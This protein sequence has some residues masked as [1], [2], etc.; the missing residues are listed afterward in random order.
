M[1][2]RIVERPA[3]LRQEA[4][5]GGVG[6]V[7]DRGVILPLRLDVAAEAA[8]QVGPHGVEEVVVIEVEL[9]YRGERLIW[10]VHLGYGYGAIERRYRARC[11]C[12]ELIIQL[13]DLPP[14]GL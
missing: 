2:R 7:R 5:F 8:Q 13:E 3:P 4:L 1:S 6:A 14:V 11:E 9:I 10:P 12:H